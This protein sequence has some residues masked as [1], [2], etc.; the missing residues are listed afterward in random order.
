MP[1]QDGGS[2]DQSWVGSTPT[3]LELSIGIHEIEISRPGYVPWSRQ[4][5][6]KP[7]SRVEVNLA[8]EGRG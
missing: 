5:R 1:E 8:R 4:V 2:V 7:G 6:V 3:E